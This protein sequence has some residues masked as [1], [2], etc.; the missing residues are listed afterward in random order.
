M[1]C[2]KGPPMLL[3]LWYCFICTFVYSIVNLHSLSVLL[4][5]NIW[6]F[7]VNGKRIMGSTEEVRKGG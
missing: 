6:V 7:L 4:S 2:F 5:K 1:Q 3:G